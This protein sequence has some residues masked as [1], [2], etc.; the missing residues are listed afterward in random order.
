[1]KSFFLTYAGAHNVEGLGHVFFTVELA[2]NHNEPRQVYF[3]VSFFGQLKTADVVGVLGGKSDDKT[4]YTRSH[5]QKG[6]AV[7]SREPS[8]WWLRNILRPAVEDLFAKRDFSRTSMLEDVVKSTGDM[9][10]AKDCVA[11]IESNKDL[12]SAQLL[13][14][15]R[16]GRNTLLL[17]KLLLLEPR[18]VLFAARC[19]EASSLVLALVSLLPRLL[20]SFSPALQLSMCLPKDKPAAGDASRGLAGGREKSSQSS[21]YTPTTP[22][23]IRSRLE[24]IAAA[25]SP[26][27]KASGL[28]REVS[29]LSSREGCMDASASVRAAAS[30]C[31]SV[32][33]TSSSNLGEAEGA[34]LQVLNLL[35]LLVQKDK[36]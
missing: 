7:L 26:E 16:F 33:S 8:F 32:S 34:T 6:I 18:L 25:C 30:D 24:V 10:K 17:L 35:A 12:S 5:V 4:D 20:H 29:G 3:G 2:L 1:M 11:F 28:S 21:P 14:V 36:Y 13:L 27:R 9:T 31:A 19:E 22:T 15:R 23:S